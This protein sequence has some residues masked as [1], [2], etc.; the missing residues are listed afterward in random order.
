QVAQQYNVDRTRVYVAGMSSGAAM[1]TALGADYPD[2]FAAVAAHSGTEYQP[3][4]TDNVMEC[5]VDL[6]T[7]NASQDPT[8]SGKAA[9]A[10]GASFLQRIVPEII[11]HGDYDTVVAPYNLTYATKSISVMYDGVAT[12]GAFL[13]AITNVPQSQ[14][15]SY[16][17]GGYDYWDYTAANGN[18]EWYYIHGMNHAWSG[19]VKESA[20][21]ASDG[22]NYN[23]PLGPPATQ[24][25]RQ[26]LFAHQNFYI[27]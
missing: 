23:D 19:G 20:S 11:F 9:W 10:Q 16:Q 13:G 17:P 25:F 3:C 2:V 14:R 15:W 27:Y 4:V 18:L 6:T 22:N 24:I 26:F 12:N 7:K 5:Y 8:A 1:A 21:N